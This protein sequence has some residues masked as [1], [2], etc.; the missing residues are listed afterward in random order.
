M[1]VIPISTLIQKKIQIYI[2]S[3]VDDMLFR[4]L[5]LLFLYAW[6]SRVTYIYTIGYNMCTL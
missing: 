2:N 4:E 1:A 5:I 3:I 6:S